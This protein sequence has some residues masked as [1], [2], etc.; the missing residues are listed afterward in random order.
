MG[1]LKLLLP[2]LLLITYIPDS[3]LSFQIPSVSFSNPPNSRQKLNL[4]A[5]PPPDYT[6]DEI[7]PIA[8]RKPMWEGKPGRGGWKQ[9][10]LEK[11]AGWA[12]STEANRPIVCEFEP[13][14]F[15]LWT[16]WRGTVLSFT[17]VN[18]LMT[19]AMC[20]MLDWSVHTFS[21]STWPILNVPPMDDPIVQQLIGV[22]KLWEYLLTLCTFILTFFISETYRFWKQVYFTTRAIQGR[23]NDICMLITIGSQRGDCTEWGCEVDGMSNSENIHLGY[24]S[25]YSHSSAKLVRLCSRLIKLSHAFFWAATP[26]HSDGVRD[27]GFEDGSHVIQ[28]LPA[29]L[30]NSDIIGP[31]LL[32]PEGLSQLVA[33]GELTELEKRALIG[34]GLPPSQ[35][36]YIML[37]WVGIHAMNGMKQGEIVGGPGLEENI[38]KQL[39]TLRAE[40]FNIGDM[41]AGRMV[42]AYV[43][44]VQVLVDSLVFLAPFALYP[45][46]GSLAIPLTGM[47]TL[48]FKGLLELSKSFLD[49]FGVEGSPGQNIRIDVLVSELNFGAGSRW[50][51]SGESL[52]SEEEIASWLPYRSSAP[53]SRPGSSGIV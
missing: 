25:G 44:L 23:I 2:T 21:E 31:L 22:N 15:W 40:Y 26:T 13:H 32:S 5:I 30:E 42:L 41:M 10:Q 24:T 35:Y 27:G 8:N 53:S 36:A 34:S 28:G 14:A 3:V 37:E 49:P 43:Q 12:A 11:V 46:V 16:R 18:V 48:F 29:E 47:F 52:P 4:S 50:V 7:R 33:E 9:G 20:A 45:E 19:M 1:L 6:E 17:F 38:L 51:K 39:N